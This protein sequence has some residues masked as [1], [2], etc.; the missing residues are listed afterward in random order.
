MNFSIFPNQDYH[1]AVMMC[2]MGV[3]ITLE[4]YTSF[5]FR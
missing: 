1:V 3:F 5:S 4:L 2:F